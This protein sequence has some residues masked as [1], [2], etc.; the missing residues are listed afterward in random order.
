MKA[1]GEETKDQ[2]EANEEPDDEAEPP[3]ID[4]MSGIVKAEEEEKPKK[5]A[6][7]RKQTERSKTK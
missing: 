4:V 7:T 6:R 2:G 3:E 5:N 1:S